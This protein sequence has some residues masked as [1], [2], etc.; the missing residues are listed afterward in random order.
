[1]DVRFC[2][3]A[4]YIVVEYL[5]VVVIIIIITIIILLTCS[6]KVRITKTVT[7]ITKVPVGGCTRGPQLRAV[8]QQQGTPA[9]SAVD[10]GP[11]PRVLHR[12]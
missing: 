5:D 12:K 8:F 10:L 7:K 3:K 11:I 9:L 4:G 2:K 6:S 1:M